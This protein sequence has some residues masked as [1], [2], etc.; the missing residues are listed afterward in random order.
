MIIEA[1]PRKQSFAL[2]WALSGIRDSSMILCRSVS[3]ANFLASILSG[4][5]SSSSV[6]NTA[7]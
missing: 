7:A 6:M 1:G 4:S 2:Y 5:F 3:S